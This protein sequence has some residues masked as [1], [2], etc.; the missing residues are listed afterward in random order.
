[1][2]NFNNISASFRDLAHDPG[3]RHSIPFNWGVTGIV[4]RTDLLDAP[5]TRWADLWDPRY[6]GQVGVWP[7]RRD[8]LGMSL[9]TLG[10]SVNSEEPA[11]VEA[12]LDHL[13]TLR[14]NAFLIDLNLPHAASYLLDGEAVAVYGWAY[15][16]QEAQAASDEVAF[17]LPEE[18]TIL[19][20]EGL[21][22]P[23]A[24]PNKAAAE[25]FIDFLLRPEISAQGDVV[26]GDN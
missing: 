3:N 7:L 2:P 15:D 17:V 19:W 14:D 13:L 23:A 1:V 5:I 21:V 25:L 12:A 10:Y 16:F 20:G 26:G 4:V 22:I 24:S 6:Q 9:K 8:L 18:G 11:E